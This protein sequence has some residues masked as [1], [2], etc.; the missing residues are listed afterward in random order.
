[1]KCLS[2][3]SVLADETA[4]ISGTEQISIGVW[5]LGYDNVNEKNL[6][7]EEFLVYTPLEKLYAKSVTKTITEVLKHF[8]FYL[9]RI[10]GQGYDGCASSF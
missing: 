9:N 4:D 6:I 3:F 10:V 1:M 8:G 5:Y 2:D 7:C